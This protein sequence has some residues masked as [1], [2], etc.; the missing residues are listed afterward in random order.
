VS[1]LAERYRD[2]QLT[3]EF[4]A[5]ASMTDL[6]V[7]RYRKAIEER[8]RHT[9]NSRYYVQTRSVLGSFTKGKG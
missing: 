1:Q 6:T 3:N 8:I 9:L 7:A 2:L 4:F 5:G